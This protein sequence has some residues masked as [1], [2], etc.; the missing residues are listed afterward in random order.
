MRNEKLDIF[1][2]L[3]MIWV[4]FNHTTYWL[5]FFYYPQWQSIA[6]SMLLMGTQLFFFIAGASNGMSRKKNVLE[7]YLIRFKR[8]LVPYWVYAIICIIITSIIKDF[9]SS[10]HFFYFI[11]QALYSWFIA[12]NHQWA[13]EGMVTWALWFIP[14]YL[15]VMLL[16]PFLRMFFEKITTFKIKIIPLLIFAA[17]VFLLQFD[18][19][20][21]ENLLKHCKMVSFYGFFTYL[22]LFFTNIFKK[23]R[24]GIAVILAFLCIAATT[25]S[26]LFLNQSPNMQTNKFP[27]NFLFLIF[28][29]GF[30]AVLYIFSNPIVKA[31][32]FCRK[33]IILDWVYTQYVK[34]GVTIFLFH[35][36]VFIL[37]LWLKRT[38]FAGINQIIVFPI[39]L[40]LSIT[41]SA[42][43][44][45][46]FAWV[47]KIKLPVFKKK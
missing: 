25:F 37:L 26:I 16:F 10:A 28:S 18:L 20:I 23:Q 19:G 1:R 5:S 2:G 41:L 33:N 6:K 17:L 45:Y 3:A 13:W 12:I 36:F 32:T 46:L 44:G 39:M 4:V 15:L 9:E 43:I 22:G 31:I 40:L 14:V 7:F 30:F 21:E 29:L 47:E 42:I 27:P 8:I 38:F 11:K 24:T 34:H 35:S